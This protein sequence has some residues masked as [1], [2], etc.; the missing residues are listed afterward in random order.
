MPKKDKQLGNYTLYNVCSV[1]HQGC[2]VHGGC[3]VHYGYHEYIGGYHEYIGGG[4]GRIW[5]SPNVLI[6]SPRCTHGISLM[7]WTS[8]DVLMISTH[9][10]DNTPW[11]THGIPLMY[12]T[13]IAQGDK[14]NLEDNALHA[15]WWSKKAWHTAYR[16]ILTE[17]NHS[18][19]AILILY[20]TTYLCTKFEVVQIT[21]N[22]VMGQ[23]SWRIFCYVTW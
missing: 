12:W 21:E 9:M 2:S 8:S 7:Y 15:E 6:I 11:C 5:T 4:G 10:H 17:S 19:Y 3:L 22:R 23:R 16:K 13:H 18:E 1:V 14:T 20:H